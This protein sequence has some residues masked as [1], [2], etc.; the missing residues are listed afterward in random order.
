MTFVSVIIIIITF[1]KIYDDTV[2]F[3][4]LLIIWQRFSFL[5]FAFFFVNFNLSFINKVVHDL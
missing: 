5:F 4:F 3:V 1:A 2:T